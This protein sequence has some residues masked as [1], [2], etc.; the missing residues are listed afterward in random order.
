MFS[1][2]RH[3]AALLGA[4]AG[5]VAGAAG[6]HA[7][8]VEV[9]LTSHHVAVEYDFSGANITLFGAAV[10]ELSRNGDEPPDVIIAVRGPSRTTRVH[11]KERIAGIWINAETKS[12]EPLRNV[13]RH[14]ASLRQTGFAEA[15]DQ[16]GYSC[17]V[18]IGLIF[19]VSGDRKLRVDLHDWAKSR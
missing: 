2:I 4:L 17:F 13:F 12:F 6:L 16:S 10:G 15:F 19:E 18:L 7:E 11:R 5:L 14:G 3:T 9:D 8:E 1:S